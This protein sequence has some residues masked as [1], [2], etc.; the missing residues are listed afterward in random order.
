MLNHLDQKS[1][2]ELNKR[3]KKEYGLIGVLVLLIIIDFIVVFVF[4]KRSTM[5]IFLIVG[6]LTLF[7]CLFFISLVFFSLIKPNKYYLNLIKKAQNRLV[8]KTGVVLEKKEIIFREQIEFQKY[9][10]QFDQN[11]SQIIV[12]NSNPINLLINKTYD[13][14]IYDSHALRIDEVEYETK[15]N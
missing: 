7:V 3:I 5:H 13:F 4:Q 10:V 2:E 15:A 9:L 14:Y 11:K 8:K 6:S 12:E 1:I